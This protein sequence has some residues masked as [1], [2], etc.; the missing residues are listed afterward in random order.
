MMQ[1]KRKSKTLF[2]GISKWS[3]YK[4]LIINRPLL[5][6]RKYVLQ[7]YCDK[8]K[9][10]YGIDETNFLDIY[11]R[12]IIRKQI[13]KWTE[14]QFNTKYQSILNKNKK[15]HPQYIQTQKTYLLWEQ[16]HWSLT[17]FSKLNKQLQY[18][19]IYNI[20]SNLQ[21]TNINHNKII[22]AITFINKGKY[23]SQLRLGNNYFFAKD[24][25]NLYIINN[26]K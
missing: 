17:F 21:L 18:H 8:H 19:L 7:S 1:L 13:T 12:N 22:L 15:L 6:K 10:P 14:K 23:K 25:I 26:N 4:S 2:Y 16:S 9:I 3:M 5:N 11:E 20:F 24:N